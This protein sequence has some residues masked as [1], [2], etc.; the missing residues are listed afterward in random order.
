LTRLVRDRL[1]LV[2]RWSIAAWESLR[3][4]PCLICTSLPQTPVNVILK[5]VEGSDHPNRITKKQQ[6]KDS[7]FLMG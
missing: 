6:S 4:N 2:E 3:L 5:I 1:Y 7:G